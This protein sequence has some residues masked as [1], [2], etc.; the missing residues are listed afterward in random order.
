MKRQ[1]DQLLTTIEKERKSSTKIY[2]NESKAQQQLNNL[3]SQIQ[4]NENNHQADVTALQDHLAAQNEQVTLQER[5]I[6]FLQG[7]IQQYTTALEQAHE[8]LRK[9]VRRTQN[10]ENQAR[11]N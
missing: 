4:G 2:N 6:R 8:E 11:V 3:R 1:I 7:R 5:E 9:A 10:F